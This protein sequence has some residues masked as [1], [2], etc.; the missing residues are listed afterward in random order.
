MI[1][2]PLIKVILMLHSLLVSF[3]GF[4][5]F[6][7]RLANVAVTPLFQHPHTLL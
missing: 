5:A 7:R 6:K 4:V 2:R 1:T 3:Q